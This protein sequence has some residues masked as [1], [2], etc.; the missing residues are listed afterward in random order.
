MQEPLSQVSIN[1][2]GR[3]ECKGEMNVLGRN[4]VS[5][6]QR[7]HVEQVEIHRIVGKGLP[8]F[9]DAAVLVGWG[10]PDGRIASTSM[11]TTMHSKTSAAPSTTAGDGLHKSCSSFRCV[12]S[13]DAGQFRRYGA[14][15]N[16]AGSDNSVSRAPSV[17]SRSESRT[18]DA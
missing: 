4:I 3:H 13:G 11:S 1:E 15:S 17:S 6:I 16:P 2:G 14:L 5:E 8:E 12:L 10:R 9:Q 18:K 7:N